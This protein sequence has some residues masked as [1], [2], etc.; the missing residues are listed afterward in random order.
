[1]PVLSILCASILANL[2]RR[3]ARAQPFI[4]RALTAPAST[5]SR[6]QCSTSP[7]HLHQRKFADVWPDGFLCFNQRYRCSL[8]LCSRQPRQCLRL[9]RGLQRLARIVPGSFSLPR[10]RRALVG[11]GWGSSSFTCTLSPARSNFI[12]LG[13]YHAHHLRLHDSSCLKHRQRGHVRTGEH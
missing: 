7:A 13:N 10:A 11:W 2:R 4:V 5:P 1:V 6:H 3:L 8:R 9:H 12:S